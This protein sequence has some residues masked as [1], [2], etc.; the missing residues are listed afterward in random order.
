MWISKVLIEF[1]AVFIYL[2]HSHSEVLKVELI[3][4]GQVPANIPTQ[5]EWKGDDPPK[6]LD[7]HHKHLSR[8]DKML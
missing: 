6:T 2:V 1:S 4:T 3:S 7:Y 8:H 5:K